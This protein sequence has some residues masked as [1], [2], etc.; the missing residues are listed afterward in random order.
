MAHAVAQQSVGEHEPEDVRL[1]ELG[2]RAD[3]A[4]ERVERA[5]DLQRHL[6]GY[7]SRDV[8]VALKGDQRLVAV[9]WAGR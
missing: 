8:R 2:L 1:R 6:G 5:H 3:P 4:V 7:V 9:E